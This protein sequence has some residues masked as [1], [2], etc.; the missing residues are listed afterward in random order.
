MS[1]HGGSEFLLPAALALLAEHQLA[2]SGLDA[3]AFG[4]GPG[5]FTGLRLACGLAQGLGMALD[6]PLLP[7]GSLR[8]LAAEARRT[9][10]SA[11]KFYC[12]IDARMREAYSAAYEIDGEILSEVRAPAV[13][14]PAA[15]PRL[16]GDDWLLCGD[17]WRMP[18]IVSTDQGFLA[19]ETWPTAAAVARLALATDWQ[20]MSVSPQLASPVY[21][22]DKVA[23]TTA[24]RIARG[25]VR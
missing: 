4:A 10:P 13:S 14:S 21:V 11:T 20:A 22:R 25:G 7:V 3:I 2:L 19:P 9:L 5:S 18:G 24:E 15:L 23:F 1:A 12:C 16:P 8:A 6:R 17:G